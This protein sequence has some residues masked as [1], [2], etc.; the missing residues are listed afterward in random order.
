MQCVK[1]SFGLG[2]RLVLAGML[3][4]CPASQLYAQHP[5]AAASRGEAKPA[6]FI[7]STAKPFH[8]LMDDAMAVMSYGMRAAPPHGF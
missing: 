7:A 4:A 6:P 1:H 5:H 8:Q 3:S 2:Q